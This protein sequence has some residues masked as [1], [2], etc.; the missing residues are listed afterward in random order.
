MQKFIKYNIDLKNETEDQNIANIVVEPLERGFGITLG[1]ALRRVLLS[2]IQGAAMFAIKIPNVTHEY[3]AMN[4]VLEDVSK[5]ILN[6]KNLVI[7]IDNDIYPYEQFEEMP[8]ENWPTMTIS[9]KGLGPITGNDIVC[10]TGFEIVNPD[11]LIATVTDESV[12]FNLEIF[13]ITGRGYRTFIDNKDLISSTINLIPT[14]SDFSPVI[15]VSYE[16][17]EFKESKTSLSDRLHLKVLTNGAIKGSDA[18]C[19]A[20]H[21]L[22][23]HLESFAQL[24]D[25]IK[26]IEIMKEKT[27]ESQK[28]M[29]AIPIE[30]LDLPVRAYNGLKQAQILTTVEL[31][32]KDQNGIA[33]IKNLGRKSVDDIIKALHDKGLKLK[34]EE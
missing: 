5:I 4:G 9:K 26:E 24:N 3:Q 17:E 31:L 25:R 28:Q 27:R 18:I 13:A 30:E 34:G 22:T 15:K 11:L 33:N 6:L 20:A 8:I 10:P 32:D 21:I 7:R 29:H 1:N 16:V 12:T 2:N 14:D 19:L 23:S